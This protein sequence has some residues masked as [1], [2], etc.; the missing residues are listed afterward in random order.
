MP[1]N[2]AGG[3][4]PFPV[5]GVAGGWRD[6]WDDPD[7]VVQLR[8]RA[9]ACERRQLRCAEVLGTVWQGEIR[10]ER[11]QQRQQTTGRGS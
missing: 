7:D 11:R 5:R 9:E 4:T 6:P 10:E 2:V 8:T 3:E 1:A